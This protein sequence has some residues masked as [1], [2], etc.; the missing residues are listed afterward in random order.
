MRAE[1]GECWPPWDGGA[2]DQECQTKIKSWL[3]VSFRRVKNSHAEVD[4]LTPELFKGQ[5]HM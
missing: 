4:A 2:S 3:L 5:M 1:H